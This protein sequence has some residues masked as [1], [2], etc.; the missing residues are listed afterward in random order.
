MRIDTSLHEEYAVLTLKGEFDTFFVTRFQE[1]INSTALGAIIKLSKRCKAEGGELIASKPSPIV[2][3]IIRKLG[4][5]Q[6]LPVFDDDELA[7]KHVIKSLNSREFA[8]DAP[9]DEEK[10]LVTFPDDVRNKMLGGKRVLVGTMSNV[11]AHRVQFLFSGEKHGLKVDQVQ[12][13]FFVGGGLELKFQVKLAK[14]GHFD[15][16]AS[17]AEVQS[18]S[19]AVKVTA[20]FETMTDSDQA[21]LADYAESM[22]YLKRQIPDA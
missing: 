1:F 7:V 6:L 17:V 19:D 18:S 14:R 3:D 10:I 12:Q 21:A 8:S 5:D 13:L 4:I 11:D 20:N 22:S 2:R 9:V 15:V 16:K